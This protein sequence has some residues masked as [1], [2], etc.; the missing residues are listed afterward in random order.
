MIGK[1]T[2]EGG[3]ASSGAG[4]VVWSHE[5]GV[6]GRSHGC[7]NGENGVDVMKVASKNNQGL[8]SVGVRPAKR[9]LQIRQLHS[10]YGA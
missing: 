3:A 8:V 6:F 2:T 10:V 9:L 4:T 1:R 7:G 5:D